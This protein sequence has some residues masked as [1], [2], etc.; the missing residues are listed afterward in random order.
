MMSM[1]WSII[2]KSH[3]LKEDFTMVAMTK[4][5]PNREEVPE[6][7]TWDLA[8]IFPTDE[9]WE[10][11]FAQ[12]QTE[13][14]KIKAFQHKLGESSEQLLKALQMQDEISERLGRLY[15]YSHMRYDQ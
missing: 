6:H 8:T 13:I 12:L 14:P 11:E 10:E 1:F 15:T 5:L 4:S 9:A 2:E 7:L 3:I